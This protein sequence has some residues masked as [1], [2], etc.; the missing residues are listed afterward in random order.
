ML[1]SN[2]PSAP[3][4]RIHV[5]RGAVP[6]ALVLRPEQPVLLTVGSDPRAQICIPSVFVAPR[7]LDVLW[8]GA[9]LWLEDKLRLG[10]TFVNGQRLNEWVLVRGEVIVSFG[11]LRLWIAAGGPPAQPARPDFEAVERVSQPPELDRAATG[12][13]DRRSQT[14]RFAVPPELARALSAAGDLSA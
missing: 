11:S 5:V 7:Q 10:R 9:S 3:W 6:R 12:H 13:A 8:D 1:V 4:A 2:L 14:G